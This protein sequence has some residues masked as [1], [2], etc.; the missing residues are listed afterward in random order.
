MLHGIPM[1]NVKQMHFVDGVSTE[2]K[3]I[4]TFPFIC[5]RYF[6]IV[7]TLILRKA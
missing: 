3:H 2:D 6:K 5:I 7:V 1:Q 4:Q